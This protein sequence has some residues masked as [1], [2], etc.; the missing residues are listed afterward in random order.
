MLFAFLGNPSGCCKLEGGR[1]EEEHVGSVLLSSLPS[2]W[3]R[4]TPEQP[5]RSPGNIDLAGERRGLGLSWTAL[6]APLPQPES[7]ARLCWLCRLVLRP[8]A[9]GGALRAAEK[10]AIKVD[11]CDPSTYQN[12]SS[13]I[14]EG[15]VCLCA[16]RGRLPPNVPGDT[17]RRNGASAPP[18]QQPSPS[19]EPSG[20]SSGQAQSWRRWPR[21][22]GWS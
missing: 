22:E 4:G 21:A 15:T 18:C 19:S 13:L 5:G 3:G 9:G 20:A 8:L 11:P 14:Q 16:G 1:K 10:R 7:S 2:W 12:S 6:S 17:V